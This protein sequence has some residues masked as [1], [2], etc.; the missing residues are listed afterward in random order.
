M[1]S[2]H[3]E[4]RIDETVNECSAVKADI[5]EPEEAADNGSLRFM[6]ANNA[7]D[8]TVNPGAGV[9]PP[10]DEVPPVEDKEVDSTAILAV[11]LFPQPKLGYNSG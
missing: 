4:S 6:P 8:G 1:T 9:A 11:F 10:A 3:P 2:E 5:F 7:V